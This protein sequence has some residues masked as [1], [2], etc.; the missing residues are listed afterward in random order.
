LQVELPQALVVLMGVILQA[1][2][3]LMV[4]L[5]ATMEAAAAEQY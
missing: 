3:L 4:V 5:V 2:K 1:L